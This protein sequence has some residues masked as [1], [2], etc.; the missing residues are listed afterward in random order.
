MTELVR[1]ILHGVLLSNQKK[2]DLL[3]RLIDLH[4]KI[5][6]YFFLADSAVD[7]GQW[8]PNHNRKLPTSS[9][10]PKVTLIRLHI[11]RKGQPTTENCPQLPKPHKS[12]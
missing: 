5:V 4:K 10:T 9:K 12:P 3:T 11:D 1:I 6:F 8:G 7:S 2:V